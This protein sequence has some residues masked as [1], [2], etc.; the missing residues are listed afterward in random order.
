[1]EEQSITEFFEQDHD[2]LDHLFGEFQS[3]KRS[4]FPAAKRAFKAFMTGLK[5]HIE[6]EEQLLFPAFEQATGMRDVGPTAVMRLE[7]RQIHQALDEIHQKVR[8]QDIES[9]AAEARLVSVLGQ[10][11]FK[12]EQVLYPAIDRMVN[13]AL[14][15]EILRKVRATAAEPVH[16][17]CSCG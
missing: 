2:R 6:W 1:M 4:D 16:E 15:A 8:D 10:H 14:R 5:R 12:E 17:C 9:G 11:N 13:P 7:H 3:L